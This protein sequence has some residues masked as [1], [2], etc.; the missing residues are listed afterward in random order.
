MSEK[1]PYYRLALKWSS[2]TG[3]WASTVS[4]RSLVEHGFSPL[5]L[6]LT[7][8]QSHFSSS[9]SGGRRLRRMLSTDT[10]LSV[11]DGWTGRFC[12]LS[13][14]FLWIVSTFS[15]KNTAN[16]FAIYQRVDLFHTEPYSPASHLFTVPLLVP[17]WELY[18]AWHPM[19]W[20]QWHAVMPVIKQILQQSL[21]T[22][23]RYPIVIVRIWYRD[24]YHPAGMCGKQMIS[25]V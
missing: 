4:F 3:R 19:W 13:P 15:V 2:A 8:L 14:T 10:G 9:M 5:V 18:Q 12:D 1:A 25:N 17:E 7:A 20:I 16:L 11:T 21:V 24:Y 23:M 6:L 22:D